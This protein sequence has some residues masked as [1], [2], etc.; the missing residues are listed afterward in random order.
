MKETKNL[1]LRKSQKAMIDVTKKIK[2]LMIQKGI[3]QTELA[4]RLG[5]SQAAVSSRIIRNITIS[6]LMEILSA[7]ETTPEE[8]FKDNDNPGT[9]TT[10]ICPRCGKA[11]QIKLN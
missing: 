10:A 1:S 3:N 8:F 9:T 4:K 6:S 2:S 11:I 7:L 5:V